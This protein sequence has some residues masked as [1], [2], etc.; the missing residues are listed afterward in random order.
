MVLYSFFG[1]SYDTVFVFFFS[2]RRRHTRCALVTGVQT[3]AVPIFGFGLGE[4]V[5]A[6]A[7]R[8]GPQRVADP[9]TGRAGQLDRRRQLAQLRRADLIG[10]NGQGRPRRDR[11]SVV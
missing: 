1:W 2:S 7:D 6:D 8:L 10:E 3:C 11:K 5:V 4:F 9:G